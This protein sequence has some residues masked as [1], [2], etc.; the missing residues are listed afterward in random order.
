MPPEPGLS[1]RS[2]SSKFVN[3][4]YKYRAIYIREYAFI[5]TYVRT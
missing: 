3:L 1:S 5:L 4:L 2:N